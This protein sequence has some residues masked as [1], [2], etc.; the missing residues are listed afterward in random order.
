MEYRN[1][2]PTRMSTDQSSKN[3]TI[4]GIIV[5]LV[6]IAATWM[7]KG[8]FALPSVKAGGE[9]LFIGAAGATLLFVAAL[10]YAYK[11]V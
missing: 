9:M 5:V 3:N 4:I 8:G 11:R 6:L 1:R 10:Y 7:W 2:I